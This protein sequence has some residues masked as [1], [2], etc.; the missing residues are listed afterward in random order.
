[1]SAMKESLMVFP[2]ALAA[3]DEP[4]RSMK[5]KVEESAEPSA[6]KDSDSQ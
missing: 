1:M 4:D 2:S 5:I 3:L 6:P